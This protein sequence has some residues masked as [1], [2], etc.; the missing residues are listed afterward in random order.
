MIDSDELTWFL[1]E[2]ISVFERSSTGAILDKLEMDAFVSRSCRKCGGAG[3]ID[4]GHIQTEKRILGSRD[5]YNTYK[6][7]NPVHHKTGAWC[8]KCKGTGAEPVRL[9]AE[10]QR[11]V[12]AGDWS[13]DD[14]EGKRSSVP[15]STLIRYAHVSRTLS[16]MPSLL[17]EA[18]VMAYGDDGEG[19]SGTVHG[20]SW[21]CS[22]LTIAGCELLLKERK[23]RTVDEE[24]APERPIRCMI[25][26]AKLGANKAHP[27]RAKLLGEAAAA[28]EELLRSAERS[29]T[30]IVERPYQAIKAAL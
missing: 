18:L 6:L 1:T 23:R 29:W 26:L 11:L 17:R 20:R 22:P 25:A 2:G 12:D 19:L 14:K 24:D 15:D 16:R 21:A 10:E 8:P 5:P 13:S 28:A 9:S 27:E 4:E 30:R 7:D 3:I